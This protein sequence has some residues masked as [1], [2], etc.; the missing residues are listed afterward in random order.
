MLELRE[1][2]R[3]QRQKIN[4]HLAAAQFDMALR[5]F[6]AYK[7]AFN[8]QIASMQVGE[9]DM[10]V[11]QQVVPELIALRNEHSRYC[12]ETDRLIARHQR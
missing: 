6:H 3:A 11:Y 4:D 10:D 8:S 5:D 12:A 7:Q 2:V 1:R 9:L